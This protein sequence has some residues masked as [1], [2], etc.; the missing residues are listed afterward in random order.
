VRPCAKYKGGE[1]QQSSVT[2]FG[3]LPGVTLRSASA[4]NRHLTLEADVTKIYGNIMH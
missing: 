1:T 2:R 3:T 4:I